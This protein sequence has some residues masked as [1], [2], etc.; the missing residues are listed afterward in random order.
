MTFAKSPG[1][2]SR[3]THLRDEL[4]ARVVGGGLG[5]VSGIG[6]TGKGDHLQVSGQCR[7]HGLNVGVGMTMKKRLRGLIWGLFV[8]CL[9]AGL[10]WQ[11]VA[12]MPWSFWRLALGLFFVAWGLSVIVGGRWTEKKKG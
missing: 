5:E 11:T 12:P 3:V 6:W 8:I 2:M 1:V 4:S 9:G 10:V 7:I